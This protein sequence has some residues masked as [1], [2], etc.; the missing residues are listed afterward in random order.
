MNGI[1]STEKKCS[2]LIPI[3]F[4]FWDVFESAYLWIEAINLRLF[5]LFSSQFIFAEL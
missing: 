3:P 4:Q 1:N 5:S 2:S